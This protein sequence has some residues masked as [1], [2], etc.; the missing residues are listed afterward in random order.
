MKRKTLFSIT[1]DAKGKIE[2]DCPNQDEA[3]LVMADKIWQM[4]SENNPQLLNVLF[5]T[6]VHTAA[7]DL[8]SSFE[9]ELLEKLKSETRRY[10]EKYRKISTAKQESE[11]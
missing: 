11:S 4:L 8:S 6:L 1:Q 5:A 10:R 7:R 9:K 2:W 3:V